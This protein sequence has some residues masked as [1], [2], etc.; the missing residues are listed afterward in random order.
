M[1]RVV[2]EKEVVVTDGRESTGSNAIWA[3]AFV[4]IVGMVVGALYY[5]GALKRLTAPAAQKINVEVSA[6]AAP[7]A[8][9][10]K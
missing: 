8:P 3:I 4:I 7:P 2:V 6:P 5:S 10:N 9:A 1:D